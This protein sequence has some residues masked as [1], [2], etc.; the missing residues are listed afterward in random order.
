MTHPKR[1]RPLQTDSRPASRTTW[2]VRPRHASSAVEHAVPAPDLAWTR[3][4]DQAGPL[5]RHR[6]G[7]SV[8][9]QPACTKPPSCP[10]R[11]DQPDGSAPGPASFA[12]VVFGPDTSR[13][14]KAP[15][16]SG[17]EASSPSAHVTGPHRL[18]RPDPVVC[19][20]VRVLGSEQA[21]VQ[22]AR[23][24]RVDQHALVHAHRGPLGVDQTPGW[25][26]ALGPA[27]PGQGPG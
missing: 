16:Q 24:E 9:P 3:Y 20:P 19:N 7:R 21:L 18:T 2:R 5:V 10:A 4:P 8:G 22:R 13:R 11:P 14:P 12:S 6:P 15:G 23:S 17:A 27:R 25:V 1:L 26:Q